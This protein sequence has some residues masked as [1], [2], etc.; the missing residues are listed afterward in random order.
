MRF[1]LHEDDIKQESL[2]PNRECNAS[3]ITARENEDDRFSTLKSRSPFLAE[4]R[5]VLEK[6]FQESKYISSS[7][8]KQLASELKL[9]ERQI[10]VKSR[11]LRVKSERL[12]S[13][14]PFCI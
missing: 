1:L 14:V 9:T 12:V 5:E 4:Q 3:S 10:K 6:I 8:R 7:K 2:K 13:N 11:E